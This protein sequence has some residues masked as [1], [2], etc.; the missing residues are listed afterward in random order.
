M[1]ESIQQGD[2]Y[3]LPVN[4][5]FNGLKVVPMT[6]SDQAHIKADGVRV[7]IGEFL[8]YDSELGGVFYNLT[9]DQW[10]F[11]LTEYESKRIGTGRVEI[12]IG[13][14]FGDQ[15]VHTPAQTIQV[16]RSIIRFDWGEGGSGQ[17]LQEKTVIPTED[18]QEVLPDEGYAA[19]SKV[20]VGNIPNDYVGSAVT[21]NPAL[22]ASG[23]TVMAPA[24]YYESAAN[25]SVYEF[26][27]SEIQQMFYLDAPDSNGRV[28]VHLNPSKSGWLASG[29]NWYKDQL[30]PTES[31]KTVTPTGAEQIAVPAGKWTLGDIKVAAAPG[32]PSGTKQIASNGT[33]DVAAYQYA[34][35]NVSGGGTDT[36]DATATA[37]DILSGKTAYAQGS[38]LTGTHTCLDTSDATATAGEIA[39]GKTAYV[40]GS[41]V[42]GSMTNN[43]DVSG[44]ISTKNGNVQI[45]AGY[46]SGG[47]VQIASS[48]IQKIKSGN[49][50]DGVTILGQTGQFTHIASNGAGAA[51]IVSGKKAYVNGELVE[52]TH[53]CPTP[54]AS[55][56]KSKTSNT[57][58]S[59]TRTYTGLDHEPS[60]FAAVYESGGGSNTNS[61]ATTVIFDGD[62]LYAVYSTG[63]GMSLGRT[64]SV[65][66]SYSNGTLT[67]HFT[68]SVIFNGT[69][70]LIYM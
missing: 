66:K 35:V 25:K 23:K 31:G 65:S 9:D 36:S 57:G 20:N 49:I 8:K 24:G 40:N 28:K 18:F 58:G 51:D 13:V 60:F 5:T 3:G 38:K 43:G 39:A 64:T 62:S 54:A 27:I 14:K 53:V 16:D 61:V 1:I 67:L 19:L 48:E 63:V 37:A 29:T 2:Q 32:A 15:Y 68:N 7:Q 4:I 56:D 12:Q 50:K 45:P 70:R 17:A 6:P 59:S 11:P 10:I 42:T 55:L 44:Q 30:L 46:T 47:T 69:Y 33:H 21:R 26:T 41:K 34:E 52:G 22:T